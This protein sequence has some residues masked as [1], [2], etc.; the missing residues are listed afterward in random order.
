ML[1]GGSASNLIP[2]RAI[3]RPLA[4]GEAWPAMPATCDA[5]VASIRV[6]VTSRWK[7]AALLRGSGSRLTL[8]PLDHGSRDDLLDKLVLENLR[9]K[10]KATARAIDSIL[11]LSDR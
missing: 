4:S 7:E 1:R 6:D 9:R 5:A 2:G 8:T 10:L 11:P 3:D